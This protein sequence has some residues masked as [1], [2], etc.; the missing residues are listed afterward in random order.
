MPQTFSIAMA[1]SICM[2]ARYGMGL[3]WNTLPESWLGA[4]VA[5]YWAFMWTYY[6][7]LVFTKL[8]ILTQYLRIFPQ[9]RFLQCCYVLLGVV[10]V[11]GLWAVLSAI[12]MCVPV[13][14]FWNMNIFAWDQPQCLPR[15][16]IW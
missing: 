12:F 13:A 14:S 15:I 11:W 3:H 8:S 16:T 2:Q 1:A 4:S 5:W 6:A 10:S 9:Q 7:A